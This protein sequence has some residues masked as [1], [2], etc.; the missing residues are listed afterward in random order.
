MISGGEWIVI[1]VVAIVLVLWGPA[2]IPE[3]ARALGKAKGEFDKA[4]KEFERMA[5]MS[6]KETIKEE[7]SSKQ[8]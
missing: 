6:E 3:L 2:K 5:E 8:N 7:R 4:T 1:L